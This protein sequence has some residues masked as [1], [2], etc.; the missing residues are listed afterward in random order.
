MLQQISDLIDIISNPTSGNNEA[1]FTTF[2]KL[3]KL[4]DTK[5]SLQLMIKELNKRGSDALATARSRLRI[6]EYSAAIVVGEKLQAQGDGGQAGRDTVL[7]EKIVKNLADLG[8]FFEKQL[9]E[10]QHLMKREVLEASIEL[11]GLWEDVDLFGDPE[12]DGFDDRKILNQTILDVVIRM[13]VLMVEEEDSIL[14]LIYKEISNRA[15]ALRML[16]II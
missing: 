6:Q 9:E 2:R 8:K 11:L 13:L 1:I 10:E 3:L 15:R 4:C 5:I 16:G 12:H 14:G 7:D